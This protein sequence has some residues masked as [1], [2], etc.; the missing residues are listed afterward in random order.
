MGSRSKRREIDRTEALVK[1]IGGGIVGLALLV[2]GVTGFATA[3]MGIVFLA[4]IV[5]VVGLAAFVILRSRLLVRKKVGLLL[6]LSGLLLAGYWNISRQPQPWSE[7]HAMVTSVSGPPATTETFYSFHP[8]DSPKDVLL[9][10]AQSKTWDRLVK[11]RNYQAASIGVYYNPADP[12]EV[13]IEPVNKW[14]RT[15]ATPVKTNITVT[16]RG[17]ATLQFGSVLFPSTATIEGPQVA[18]YVPG[19]RFSVWINPTNK[20]EL[21][22]Q[23]AMT[24]PGKKYTLVI[25]AALMALGGIVTLVAG[26]EWIDPSQTQAPENATPTGWASPAPQAFAQTRPVSQP[27]GANRTEARSTSTAAPTWTAASVLTALGEIDWF[28]FERFCGALLRTE[29][30]EVTRKGGA[31]PDGGVDLIAVKGTERILVQCK[32]W[33]TWTVQERVIREMLGSMTHF[34]VGRGAIYTLGGWTKPAAGFALGHSITLVDGEE[35]A[36]RAVARLTPEQL[37]K[38]LDASEHHCP[39]CEAPMVWREGNF[40]SFWG[41]S[42]YP[43]CRMTLKHSGAR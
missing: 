30:Y 12:R 26:K 16:G 36:R 13:S 14:R 21:R 11:A 37:D 42:T 41:C 10:F 38:V 29:G 9:T 35:L 34:Q 33:R 25:F 1:L 39:K 18:D 20:T 5:G 17:S 2:G 6:V 7:E 15:R 32:H 24:D 40:R 28:Q 27:A 31:Q 22:L 43:R 4:V 8:D 3:L 19:T 23:P